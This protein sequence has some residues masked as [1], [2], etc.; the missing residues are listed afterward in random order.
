[1]VIVAAYSDPDVA[2]YPETGKVAA[3]VQGEHRF[4]RVADAVEHAGPE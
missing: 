3:V 2:E 1:V 4:H